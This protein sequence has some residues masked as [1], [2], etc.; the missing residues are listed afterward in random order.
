[1]SEI[2]KSESVIV[3]WVAVWLCCA[4]VVEKLA[5]LERMMEEAVRWW[6]NSGNP[7]NTKMELRNESAQTKLC[8]AGQCYASHGASSG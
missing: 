8:D 2:G 5:W 3:V 7:R 6:G 4:G 1:M